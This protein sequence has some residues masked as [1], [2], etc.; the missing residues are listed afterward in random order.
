MSRKFVRNVTGTKLKGE[1]I[2]PFDTNVQNDLLSD[3]TDVY[4]R[5]E[6]SKDIEDKYH[7]LTDDVKE[8]ISNSDLISTENFEHGESEQE[9][10]NK[11][12]INVNKSNKT[13]SEKMESN[14]HVMTP[15][16]TGYAIEKNNRDVIPDLVKQHETP[17]EI[18][19]KSERI[20]VKKVKKNEFE[21]DFDDKDL[22]SKEYVDDKIGGV[23]TS[24]FVKSVNSKK[25]H[26]DGNVR[27]YKL[28]IDLNNVMDLS[29]YHI[30]EP[31]SKVIDGNVIKINI[32]ESDPFH[33]GKFVVLREHDITDSANDRN[34]IIIND[35]G[36]VHKEFEIVI[37][38]ISND[39]TDEIEIPIPSFESYPTFIKDESPFILKS[40]NTIFM[41]VRHIYGGLY[42][43][44]EEFN[45]EN[46]QTN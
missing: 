15:L 40:G 45:S 33:G 5:Q 6:R 1:K 37:V 41:T 22:A 44:T 26:I 3:E 36:R 9:D 39:D 4:V 43:S 25:P 27:L 11:S 24:K 2:E 34:I 35:G 29:P 16:Q 8:V 13:E 14:S 19:S 46:E 12:Y 28:D 20:D 21:L 30:G 7:C 38:F 32:S 42:I 23:D 17:T 31:L 18:E 10:K